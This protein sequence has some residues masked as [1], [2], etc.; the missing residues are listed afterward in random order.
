MC[1]YVLAKLGQVELSLSPA[2]GKIPRTVDSRTQRR[3]SPIHQT[4]VKTITHHVP[5]REGMLLVAKTSV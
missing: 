2:S 5:L 3:S 4:K 1:L